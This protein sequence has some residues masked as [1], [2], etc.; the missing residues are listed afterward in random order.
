MVER[1]CVCV[2]V[3]GEQMVTALIGMNTAHCRGLLG[4]YVMNPKNEYSTVQRKTEKEDSNWAVAFKLRLE[5]WEEII[6]LRE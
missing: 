5:W 2:C 1:C 6:S 4:H 3:G